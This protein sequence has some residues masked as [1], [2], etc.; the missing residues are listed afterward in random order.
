VSPTFYEQAG[1]FSPV[2][3]VCKKKRGWTNHFF[4]DWQQQKKNVREENLL[5]AQYV[6]TR[7]KAH[8]D[9]EVLPT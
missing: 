9:P 6:Q 8:I 4:T 1:T 2:P 5:Q 3:L 7:E